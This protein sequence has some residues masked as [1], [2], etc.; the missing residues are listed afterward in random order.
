MQNPA[1][2][3]AA[4]ASKY[5]LS[6]HQTLPRMEATL[7]LEPHGHDPGQLWVRPTEDEFLPG[8]QNL[9]FREVLQKVLELTGQETWLVPGTPCQNR[10]CAKTP[11]HQ[12][13]SI[14]QPGSLGPQQTQHS[15]RR[16]DTTWTQCYAQSA[17]AMHLSS[18]LPAQGGWWRR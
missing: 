8:A 1:P 13:T 16:W 10:H 7:G 6:I 12:N 2:R 11:P 14:P 15:W 18:A 4:E 5:P 17:N 9:H 3:T